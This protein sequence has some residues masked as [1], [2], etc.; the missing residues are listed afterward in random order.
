M[1]AIDYLS[2][3]VITAA[4]PAGPSAEIAN[5]FI[6]HILLKLI[7]LRVLLSDSGRPFLAELL[8]KIL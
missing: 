4:L 8:Q 3:S 2:R 7:A 5:F 6:Y 1:V